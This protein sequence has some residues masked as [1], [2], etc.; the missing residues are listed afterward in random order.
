MLSRYH[1]FLVGLANDDENDPQETLVEYLQQVSLDKR[2]ECLRYLKDEYKRGQLTTLHKFRYDYDIFLWPPST[3]I[4]LRDGRG[5]IDATM[6]KVRDV[7]KYY[8]PKALAEAEQQLASVFVSANFDGPLQEA[9]DILATLEATQNHP[10]S[11]AQ[12]LEAEVEPLEELGEFML[13]EEA[14]AFIKRSKSWLYKRKYLSFKLN[15]GGEKGGGTNYYRKKDLEA[16]LAK[17]LAKRK[18]HNSA[19]AAPPLD[20][21]P[22]Q[23]VR[24][25]R[26]RKD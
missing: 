13:I 8:V 19:K 20:T 18:Q 2:V 9:Q 15:G 5:V 21:E 1:S 4:E 11:L 16:E 6:D 17:G 14:V 26:K 3:P 23:L 22:S 12:Q 7:L 24:H 25:N 10:T